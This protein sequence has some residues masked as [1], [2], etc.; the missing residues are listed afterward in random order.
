M[1]KIYVPEQ[2]KYNEETGTFVNVKETTLKLEHSLISLRKW[3]SKYHKIF[4][5]SDE[6]TLKEFIDYIVCMTINR[7]KVDQN[8]YDCLTENDLMSIVEYIKDPMTATWFSNNNRVGAS[9]RT[10]EQISAEIIYY[11][12]ITFRVPV[13]FEKWHLNQLLTLLKV[14]NIKSG[15][16]KKM[17]RKESAAQRKSL[18]L[19]RRAKYKSKG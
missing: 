13:E 2:E 18:N 8:V 12:M 3:E 19:A 17:S 10:G 16:E 9:N 7:E 5:S 4:L 14:I 15:G 1:L 11:W 6:K